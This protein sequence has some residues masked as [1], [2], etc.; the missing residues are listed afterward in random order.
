MVLIHKVT[1]SNKVQTPSRLQGF[2]S[3]ASLWIRAVDDSVKLQ[4]TRTVLKGPLGQ[5]CILFC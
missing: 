2:F 4:C 1:H 3:D 5:I